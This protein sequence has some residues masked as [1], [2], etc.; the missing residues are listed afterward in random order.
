MIYRSLVSSMT[1]LMI[2]LLNIDSAIACTRVVYLGPDDTIFT[3]RTMDWQTEMLTNLWALPRGVQRN[4]A[5]GENSI[6][7][8]S[9]YGSVIASG[10]DAGTADG[11]NEEGLVANLLYLVE[12]EYVTPTENDPR[13]PLSIS[14][15]AQYFLDNY[16]T[17]AEAVQAMSQEPFYIVTTMTPDG[18]PG[19]LHLSLSDATGDS[20]IFEYVDGKLQIHHS[21]Q[22]QVMTNSPIYEQQLALNDYWKQIGGTTMLPGTNRA[23]DRFVRASFYINAIPQTS[24]VDEATASVFSVIRN[25]SVPRGISTPGQPNISSTL[26][27]TV[28]D[29]KNKRYFFE[30]TRSPNVFWVNLSDLNFTEEASTMKLTLKDGVFYSGNVAK[31]FQPAEPFVFLPSKFLSSDEN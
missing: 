15:W 12:S 22:Y 23:A 10:F 11:M 4:G 8:T 31:Q 20:A 7:W 16:A 14:L 17:V 1:A 28:A 6:E 9:K 26:W 27:R 24:D 3:A 30:S 13:K 29:Q 19:Q 21:R 5:A 25:V 2:G 18:K